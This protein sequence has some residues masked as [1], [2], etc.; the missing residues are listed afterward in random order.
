MRHWGGKLSAIGKEKADRIRR[1][2]TIS[3]EGE[4]PEFPIK[5][6]EEWMHLRPMAVGIPA[7]CIATAV[8]S[9]SKTYPDILVEVEKVM[10][11]VRVPNK[12][13]LFIKTSLEVTSLVAD[14]RKYVDEMAPTPMGIFER[15]RGQS[16]AG[17]AGAEIYERYTEII[18]RMSGTVAT[19]REFFDFER[20][21]KLSKLSR[22]RSDPGESGR[23]HGSGERVDIVDWVVGER[24]SRG[25]NPRFYG[26]LRPSMAWWHHWAGEEVRE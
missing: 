23:E 9:A 21:L 4:D 17:K 8:A 12:D 20:V 19:L 6:F 2:D 25:S 14:Y 3:K 7:T 15:H 18:K 24:R 10:G 11:S 22:P 26:Q 1:V 5:A 13:A 16:G